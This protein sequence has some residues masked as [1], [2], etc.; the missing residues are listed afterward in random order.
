MD[1]QDL[2]MLNETALLH[3]EHVLDE[4]NDAWFLMKTLF[5]LIFEKHEENA[6]NM[7]RAGNGRKRWKQQKTFPTFEYGE[8]VRT[9]SALLGFLTLTHRALAKGFKSGTKI[10]LT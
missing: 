9:V 5:G 2:K 1:A 6:L 10:Y 4:E 3:I 7:M 8:G